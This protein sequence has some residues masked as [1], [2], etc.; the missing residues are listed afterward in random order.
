MEGFGSSCVAYR[1]E[2]SQLLWYAQYTSAVNSFFFQF[3]LC[4]TTACNPVVGTSFLLLESLGLSLSIVRS[5]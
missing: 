5:V 1:L 3:A 4:W 2:N